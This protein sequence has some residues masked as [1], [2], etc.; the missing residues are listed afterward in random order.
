[1]A[2]AECDGCIMNGRTRAIPVAHVLPAL[3]RTVF[4]AVIRTKVPLL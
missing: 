1:M 3:S 4:S 2:D